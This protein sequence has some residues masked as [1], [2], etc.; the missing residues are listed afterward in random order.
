LWRSSNLFPERIVDDGLAVRMLP[1]GATVFVRL[2]RWRWI[3]DW[4]IGLSQK[5]NPGMRAGLLSRKRYI[6]EKIASSRNEIEAV[7]SLGAGFDTRSFRLPGLSGLPLWEIDQRVNID[8][9]QKRL[10]KALGAIAAN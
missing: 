1:L 5:S 4:L 3:R 6:D 7:V 2:L 10:R 9:K 8:A